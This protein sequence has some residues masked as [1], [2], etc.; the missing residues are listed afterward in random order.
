ML[1]SLLVAAVQIWHN[2][3]LVWHQICVR[4]SQEKKS[5]IKYF[6]KKKQCVTPGM[7]NFSILKTN[8]TFIEMFEIW[9]VKVMDI[10]KEEKADL[11]SR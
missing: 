2:H 9:I 1:S 6:C 5:A 8:C 7:E 10:W 11:L 3:S 4:Y